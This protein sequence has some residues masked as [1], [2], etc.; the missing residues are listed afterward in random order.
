MENQKLAYMTPPKVEL[1]K[2]DNLFL[3]LCTKACNLKCKHCYIERN[4]Y[5]NEED[6]ISLDKI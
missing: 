2:L 5:K 4:P 6:F 3:Q 1:K